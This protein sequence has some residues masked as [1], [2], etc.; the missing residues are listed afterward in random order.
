MKAATLEVLENDVDN[1]TQRINLAKN[2][3]ANLRNQAEA[4]INDAGDLKT[5]AT[6]LQE[7][8]VE[9][10]HLVSIWCLYYSNI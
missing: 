8:N 4:L 6:K 10:V 1:T 3:L 7:A 9:G 5:K 2:S